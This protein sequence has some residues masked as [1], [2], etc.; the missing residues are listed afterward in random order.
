MH[1]KL[2]IDATAVWTIPVVQCIVI[3][4]PDLPSIPVAIACSLFFVSPGDE[5]PGVWILGG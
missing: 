4:E 3:V 2:P 5:E 1:Y